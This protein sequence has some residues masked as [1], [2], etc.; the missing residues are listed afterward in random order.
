MRCGTDLETEFTDTS[1]CC[2]TSC[3]QAAC[4]AGRSCRSME[5]SV[6]LQSGGLSALICTGIMAAGIPSCLP[7]DK[8]SCSS[9]Q[10]MRTL[11]KSVA[12]KSIS[13]VSGLIVL[14]TCSEILGLGRLSYLLENRPSDL[15]VDVNR[16]YPC[17][18][19]PCCSV[20]KGTCYCRDPSRLLLLQMCCV[21]VCS[22]R[23]IA[24]WMLTS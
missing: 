6:N 21:Q 22:S 20:V 15:I 11:P 10:L 17:R 23:E 1:S 4:R 13:G 3:K 2:D 16:L 19:Y 24:I 7:Q 14:I 18:L 12:A 9:R 8:F 5:K